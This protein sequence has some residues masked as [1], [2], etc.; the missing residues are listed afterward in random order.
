MKYLSNCNN[1]LAEMKL[2][3]DFMYYLV[4]NIQ[5][6]SLQEPFTSEPP[7]GLLTLHQNL[8]V[9]NVISFRFLFYSFLFQPQHIECH[10]SAA[11]WD[12]VNKNDTDDEIGESARPLLYQYSP[13]GG[14]F[15]ASQPIPRCG[16]F[17]YLAVISQSKES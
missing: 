3:N 2:R 8:L 4:V 15:L 14:A 10:A 11:G 5:N 17:C 6:Y 16:A 13:D 12:P 1:S 9:R 7:N